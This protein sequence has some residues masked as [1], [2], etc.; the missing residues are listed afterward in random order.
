MV[1]LFSGFGA[2]RHGRYIIHTEQT[3]NLCE[4]ALR[5]ISEVWDDLKLGEVF[6]LSFI[7]HLLDS[8]HPIVLI[9]SF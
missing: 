5:Q 9:Y 2:S 4:T 6:P 3:V 8:I 1:T 7:F